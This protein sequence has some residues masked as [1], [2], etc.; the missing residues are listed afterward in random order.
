MQNGD[1]TSWCVNVFTFDTINKFYTI[2]TPVSDSFSGLY[3]F[4]ISG[5]NN[6]SATNIETLVISVTLTPDCALTTIL[7]PDSQ[8]YQNTMYDTTTLYME[9]HIALSVREDKTFP[10]DTFATS[11]AWGCSLTFQFLD[12][13]DNAPPSWIAINP[14]I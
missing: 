7:S 14:L 8:Q 10:I 1:A 4:T 6:L 12:S 5:W 11:A 2:E 13:L 3:T 9:D